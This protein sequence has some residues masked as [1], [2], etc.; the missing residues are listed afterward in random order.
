MALYDNSDRPNSFEPPSS[1][2]E[3]ERKE[4]VGHS[5]ANF[6]GW[7]VENYES[8]P[9]KV[10]LVKSNVAPRHVDVAEL[11]RLLKRPSIT[12]L[13][14][15]GGAI[16][17]HFQ[18]TQL[19]PNFYIERNNSWYLRGVERPEFFY[20]FDQLLDFVF[21]EPQP[22]KFIAFSPGACYLLTR[23]DIMNAPK[24]VYSFLRYLSAYTFFPPEDFA[25]ERILWTVFSSTEAFNDRF[26]SNNWI[27]DLSF[28]RLQADATQRQRLSK[29]LGSALEDYSCRIQAS[30]EAHWS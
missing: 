24:E 7:I 13:W 28:L 12:M 9:A 5:L 10:A 23:S 6:L 30:S 3:F 17:N 14:K 27:Q 1:S 8:L 18:E 25:V 2:H 11:S 16:G 26:S 15:K 21:V 19:H 20:S 22:R 4:N 29:R